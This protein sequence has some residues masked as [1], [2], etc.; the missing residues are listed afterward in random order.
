GQPA[1]VDRSARV[2][3]KPRPHQY[4]NDGSRSKAGPDETLS[5]GGSPYSCENKDRWVE[6]PVPALSGLT[7]RQ[8]ADDPTRREDL[9][10]LLHEFDR[11]EAPSDAA[12][13]DT[14]RLRRLLGL[15]AP[16]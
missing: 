3:T 5:D 13:S 1:P 10:A 16:Q 14:A 15:P 4:R 11:H 9:V 2:S 6:K 8:A 12:S 7:P